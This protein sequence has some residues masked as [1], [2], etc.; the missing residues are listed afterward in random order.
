MAEPTLQQVFGSNA[1][2]DLSTLTIAKSDLETVGLTISA[3]N[4]AEALF[5]AILLLAKQSLNPTAQ[6]TNQDIQITVDSGFTS[7]TFRNDTQYRQDS[8]TVNLEKPDTASTIDPDD[9]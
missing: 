5:I 9:Y 1:T 8:L 3:S 2:Q 6:E 7:I 4:R